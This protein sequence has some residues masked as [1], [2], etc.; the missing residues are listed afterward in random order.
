[1]KR[2]ELLEALE[3]VKPGLSNNE[4]LE[5]TTSFAF[6][7]GRVVT[8]N[9]ELSISHPVPDVDFEGVVRADE[10]YGL[11]KK[12]E[13][14]EVRISLEDNEIRIV[15]GRIK[16]GLKIEEEIKLPI[17]EADELEEI[18]NPEELIYFISLAMQACS[19]DTSVPM[20]T[21][22]CVKKEGIV[23]GADSPKIIVCEGDEIGYDFLI[24]A[25]SAKELIKIN[26]VTI[27]VDDNWLHFG[28]EA[29]TMLSCRK[30]DTDYLPQNKIDKAFEIKKGKTIKFP[31]K[32]EEMLE[33]A[34][35]LAKRKVQA[36][37]SVSVEI[38]NGR[39]E[40]SSEAEHTKSWV[41]EKA[42]ISCE[43][44]ISFS[45]TPSLFGD[46]LKVTK[47]CKL[48]NSNTKIK[49]KGEKWSSVIML[50]G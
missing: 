30:L 15:C 43:D 16:A 50:R 5:Q 8:Y 48:D 19:S 12:A 46:I 3:I 29:G 21:C 4:L 22:V 17:Q 49:F 2:T 18:S 11:L 6:L 25:T 36:D 38:K 32:I 37:E 40:I 31:D 42:K 41:R 39:I 20:L 28:N 33:R 35:I 7:E 9:D 24:P 44:D 23:I 1:M 14:D 47:K 27:Q 13:K 10:L 26:P 34:G 45:I